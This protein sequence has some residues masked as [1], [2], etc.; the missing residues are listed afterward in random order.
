[1]PEILIGLVAALATEG[2]KKW[3]RLPWL[4]PQNAVALRSAAA[5]LSIVGTVLTAAA[6]GELAN[7]DWNTALTQVVSSGESF[8][9]APGVYTM[10]LKSKNP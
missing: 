4:T 1:M 8:L 9:V 3:D 6:A 10:L 5:V 7:F 2:G